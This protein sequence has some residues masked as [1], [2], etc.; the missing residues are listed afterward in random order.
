MK[1][2]S[3]E[4]SELRIAIAA[5]VRKKQKF[6][7]NTSFLKIYEMQQKHKSDTIMRII[8]HTREIRSNFY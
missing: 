7:E 3:C 8:V 4:I 5:R 2:L 6:D 1:W